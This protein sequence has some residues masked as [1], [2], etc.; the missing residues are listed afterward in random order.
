MVHLLINLSIYLYGPSTFNDTASFNGNIKLSQNN[1]YEPL[2]D[3]VFEQNGNYIKVLRA[4][5]ESIYI[6]VYNKL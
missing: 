6:P 2:I 1:V 5:G 3:D 4:N